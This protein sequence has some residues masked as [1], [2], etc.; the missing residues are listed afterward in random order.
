[1]PTLCE[2]IIE[3]SI[4]DKNVKIAENL[5]D[6]TLIVSNLSGET[7]KKYELQSVAGDITLTDIEI[8]DKKT[9]FANT[10]KTFKLQLRHLDNAPASFQYVDCKGNQMETDVIRLRF[11]ECDYLNDVLNE[12]C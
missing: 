12:I 1:M 4:C 10:T 2:P 7:I 8:S 9:G 6:L 5:Q 3:L 11:I